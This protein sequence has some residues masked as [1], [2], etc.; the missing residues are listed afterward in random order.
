[1]VFDDVSAVGEDPIGAERAPSCSRRFTQAD[2][3]TA[4]PTGYGRSRDSLAV[5]DASVPPHQL[6]ITVIA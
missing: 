3:G 5:S 4:F 1:M 6:T 2:V